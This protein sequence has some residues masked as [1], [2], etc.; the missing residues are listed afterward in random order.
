MEDPEQMGYIHL[1]RYKVPPGQVLHQR[2]QVQVLHLSGH[3]LRL[4]GEGQV[5]VD[6]YSIFMPTPNAKCSR[7]KAHTLCY[8]FLT[9]KNNS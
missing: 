2:R 5:L 6:T 4:P 8:T 3:L 9:C 1:D 7:I